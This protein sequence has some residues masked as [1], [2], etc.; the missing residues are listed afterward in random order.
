[1]GAGAVG[2][3]EGAWVGCWGGWGE[4]GEGGGAGRIEEEVG[5]GRGRERDGGRYGGARTGRG[6]EEEGDCGWDGGSIQG[7]V[8][9]GIANGFNDANGSVYC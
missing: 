9:A 1:M 4:E 6:A 8:L 7:I 5:G 3:V 2:A